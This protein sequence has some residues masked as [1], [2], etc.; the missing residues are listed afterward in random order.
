MK[1]SINILLII[2][3]FA[4]LL[5]SCEKEDGGDELD[6]HFKTGANYTSASGIVA[7]GTSVLIGVEADT[8]K[9]KDPIIKFN[10]SESVNGA[11]ATSVYSE[12]IETT[13]YEYDY[14]FTMSD[15]VSGNMHTYTFTVTNRDGFNAQQ[16]L[17]LTVQ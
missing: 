14:N 8:E 10:I 5:T 2:S 12:D 13:N 16:S 1:N 9:K 7:S 6:I 15:T 17:T 4:F 3:L 11:P